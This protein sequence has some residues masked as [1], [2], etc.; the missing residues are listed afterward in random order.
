MTEIPQVK[1][2]RLSSR[3]MDAALAEAEK[4]ILPARL[5]PV[6]Q[7]FDFPDEPEYAPIRRGLAAID[8]AHDDGDL[9]PIPIELAR[10]LDLADDGEY[11]SEGVQALKIRVSARSKVKEFA[12]V[13]EAGHFLDHQALTPGQGFASLVMDGP[14]TEVLRAIRSSQAYAEWNRVVISTEALAYYNDPTE[15]WSRAYAQWV[16]QRSE[17]VGLKAQADQVIAGEYGYWSWGDFEPINQEI[18]K[19]FQK[20]GWL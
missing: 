4:L 9:P 12:L 2:A 1:A 18:E 8:A 3:A 15:M 5:R 11:W 10:D 13:C 19:V 20:R 16:G 14:L 17:S 6:S 7:A